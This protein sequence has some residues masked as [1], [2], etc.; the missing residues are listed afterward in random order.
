VEYLLV[1]RDQ[2]DADPARFGVIIND[3]AQAA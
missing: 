3:A 1:P 2:S